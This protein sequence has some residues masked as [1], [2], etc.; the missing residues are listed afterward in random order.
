MSP[1]LTGAIWRKSTKSNGQ[2]AC[3][4]VAVVDQTIAVRDSKSP[5]GPA[6]TFNHHG[7]TSFIT[8]TKK[9]PTDAV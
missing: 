6:L 9:R 8:A 7:W 1:D 2:N 4:E 5:T 3:V